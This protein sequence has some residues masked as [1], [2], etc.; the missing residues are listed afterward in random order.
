MEENDTVI[1]TVALEYGGS[2]ALLRSLSVEA[3]YRNKGIARRLVAFIET[4]ARLQGV[5][6]IYLLTT[7][8]V[9]F[10]VKMSYQAT[11]RTLAPKFVQL[12]SE[13]ISLCPSSATL[14]KKFLP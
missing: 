3:N 8:A 14:M 12:T 9:D 7:T 4:E 13:F 1:G 11:Q 10:F 6:N 2:D 5:K